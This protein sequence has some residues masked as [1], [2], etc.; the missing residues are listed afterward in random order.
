MNIILTNSDIRF[1][2]VWLAN[3]KR[4]PH[5]EIIVVRQVINA[6]HNNTDHELK[7]EILALADLSRRAGEIA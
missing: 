4:R 1:F 6:F 2:L 5:Y 7:N 3:I